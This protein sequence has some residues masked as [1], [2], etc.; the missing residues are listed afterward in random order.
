MKLFSCLL[1]VNLNPTLGRRQPSPA[2]PFP[3]RSCPL[4]SQVASRALKIPTSK[5]YISETSTNTVPNSSPTA[6]SVSTDIYGQAIYVRSLRDCRAEG[7]PKAG[8][9]QRPHIG[10]AVAPLRACGGGHASGSLHQ[11]DTKLEEGPRNHYCFHQGL[12]G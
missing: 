2:R 8:G 12:E 9:R 1:R 11:E 6:A 4:C 7:Q 5:I 3:G 10:A